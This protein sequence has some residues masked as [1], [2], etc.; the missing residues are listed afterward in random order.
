MVVIVGMD[1]VGQT[2][3]T[4]VVMVFVVMIVMVFVVM[5]VMM[6]M[7]MMFV[8]M[9]VVVMVLVIV[10]MMMFMI[11]MVLLFRFQFFFRHKITSPLKNKKPCIKSFIFYYFYNI[12]LN[13]KMNCPYYKSSPFL[14]RYVSVSFL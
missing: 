10:V 1:V 12:L 13:E 6:I 9:V 5:V 11:V 14:A 7:V 3:M 8:I 2:V 4:M